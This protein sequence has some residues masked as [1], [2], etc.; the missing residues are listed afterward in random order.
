MARRV[1]TTMFLRYRIFVT[2]LEDYQKL[3]EVPLLSLSLALTLCV[4][5]LVPHGG[6]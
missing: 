1:G 4:R 3:A 2:T 6:G 5:A